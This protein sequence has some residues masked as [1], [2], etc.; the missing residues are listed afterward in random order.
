MLRDKKIQIAQ[1][2]LDKKLITKEQLD[3]AILKQKTTNKKLGEL[4]VELGYI[5]SQKL[6]HVLSEQLHIPYVDLKNYF[7]DPEL[8]KLLPE[9]YAR[10]FR[11]I[12]LN[13][14][15]NTLVIGMA[16]PQ[17]LIAHDEIDLIAIFISGKRKCPTCNNTEENKCCNIY[18]V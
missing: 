13:R 6:Y 17:N 2:L 5:E 8:V 7:I 11:A 15:K 9:F 18:A 12:V 10:H 16:D 1:M 4:L 3:A 14:D